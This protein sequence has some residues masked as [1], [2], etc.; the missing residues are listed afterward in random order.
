MRTIP[1]AFGS[2][3]PERFFH[4]YYDSYR[5]LGCI[6]SPATICSSRASVQPTGMR[7]SA[8]DEVQSIVARLQA[9]RC[10]KPG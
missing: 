9:S 5:Y 10:M 1:G 3:W 7:Q 2:L 4:G 6:A 8:L